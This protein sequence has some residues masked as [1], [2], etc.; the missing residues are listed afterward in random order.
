MLTIETP[1]IVWSDRI[2]MFNLT[3]LD[4]RNRKAACL[5]V[6]LAPH[7]MGGALHRHVHSLGSYFEHY[8]KV[9]LSAVLS[10]L[11]KPDKC[12]PWSRPQLRTS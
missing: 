12:G 5:Q 11:H 9:I 1:T 3:F 7:T 8:A 4:E 10:F 2:W 6:Q